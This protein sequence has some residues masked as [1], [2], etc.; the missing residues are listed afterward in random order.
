MRPKIPSRRRK[1]NLQRARREHGGESLGFG[2]AESSG[3]IH[4]VT[5]GREGG[6]RWL[7]QRRRLDHSVHVDGHHGVEG[8]PCQRVEVCGTALCHGD[9]EHP[10]CALRMLGHDASNVCVPELGW[11]EDHPWVEPVGLLDGEEDGGSRRVL[12]RRRRRDGGELWVWRRGPR[13]R[14]GRGVDSEVGRG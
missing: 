8:L 2:G 7:Y 5:E 10:R 6:L 13:R 14:V 12:P 4:L 9:N 11:S 3:D 1:R